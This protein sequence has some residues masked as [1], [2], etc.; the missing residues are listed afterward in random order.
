MSRS[1]RQLL[2]ASAGICAAVAGCSSRA[3]S[4][5]DEATREQVL[6]ESITVPEDEYWYGTFEVAQSR[7]LQYEFVVREG[8]AID[9]WLMEDAE[10]DRYQ[11][12]DRFTYAESASAPDSTGTTVDAELPAGEY[13]LVADNTETGD[14]APPTNFD[15]DVA[16]IDIEVYL[17]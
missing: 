17:I 1:R 8:P 2:V 11:A 15:D 13:V 10:F 16:R 4:G 3:Q 6:D 14:A 12:N 9:M 5:D 7:R